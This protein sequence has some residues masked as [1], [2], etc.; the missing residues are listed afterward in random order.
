MYIMSNQHL[1]TKNWPMIPVMEVINHVGLAEVRY[2]KNA[3]TIIPKQI[4]IILSILLI[5]RT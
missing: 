4:N 1:R 5:T 3:T 2:S